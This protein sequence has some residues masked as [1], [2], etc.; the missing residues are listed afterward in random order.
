[1]GD[2]DM[3]KL[4]IMT[5]DE[6]VKW[7]LT[8]YAFSLTNKGE[9]IEYSFFEFY[10]LSLLDKDGNIQEG[11]EISIKPE[12]IRDFMVVFIPNVPSEYVTEMEAE[13]VKK[14]RF[15]D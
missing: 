7:S 8:K 9:D 15:K 1:M 14:E 12:L 13:V 2:I 4:L 5:D 11:K 10:R 3:K 6:D